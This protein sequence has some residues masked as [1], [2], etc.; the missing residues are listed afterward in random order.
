MESNLNK[1][2]PNY[3]KIINIT[4]PNPDHLVYIQNN[5][6]SI[7]YI[8]YIMFYFKLTNK[9]EIFTINRTI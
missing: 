9:T 4:E 2:N 7:L 1:E 8:T 3:F 5:I 6:A